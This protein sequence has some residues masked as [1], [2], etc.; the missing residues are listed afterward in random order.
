MKKALFGFGWIAV[1]L[2]YGIVFVENHVFAHQV[3][4]VFYTVLGMLWMLKQME[5]KN[6]R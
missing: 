4:A 5:G 6:D 3:D 2:F 1:Y